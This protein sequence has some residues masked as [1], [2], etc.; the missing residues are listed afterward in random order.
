[1]KSAR[2]VQASSPPAASARRLP[3]PS[4]ASQSLAAKSEAS[5]T[6]TTKKRRT[7]PVENQ[8]VQCAAQ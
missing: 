2:L 5:G 3:V 6:S 7:T 1:M 8:S 4:L